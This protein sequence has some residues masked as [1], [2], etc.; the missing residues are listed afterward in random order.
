MYMYINVLLYN[1]CLYMYN[2]M[3]M[4]MYSADEEDNASNGDLDDDVAEALNDKETE[5]RSYLLNGEQL[6]EDTLE[7]LVA[8]FWNQEPYKLALQHT[9]HMYMYL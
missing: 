3:F 1:T 6:Q 9:L 4:Y 8:P 5:I 7:S 2:Y